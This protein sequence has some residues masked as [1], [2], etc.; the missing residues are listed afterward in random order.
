MNHKKRSTEVEQLLD[1]YLKYRVALREGRYSIGLGYLITNTTNRLQELGFD[2]HHFKA[3]II[4]LEA[5][6]KEKADRQ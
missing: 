3:E 6:R 2:P 4:S 1:K 5:Y